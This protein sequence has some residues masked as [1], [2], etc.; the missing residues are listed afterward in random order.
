MKPVWGLREA[1][2]QVERGEKD[3]VVRG[4]GQVDNATYMQKDQKYLWEQSLAQAV[5]ILALVSWGILF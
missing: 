5:A 1:K 3:E 2:N 4:F